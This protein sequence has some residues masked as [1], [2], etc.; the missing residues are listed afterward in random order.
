MRRPCQIAPAVL[1][2][3]LS[4]PVVFAVLRRL[5][6]AFSATRETR[7]QRHFDRRSG[8]TAPHPSAVALEPPTP[9]QLPLK[10]A[11]GL[12]SSSGPSSC[13]PGGL[14]QWSGARGEL[15]PQ[16]PPATSSGRSTCRRCARQICDGRATCWRRQ[17]PEL[18]RL[19]HARFVTEDALARLGPRPPP[20][21]KSSVGRLQKQRQQGRPRPLPPGA[22]RRGHH[23]D[24]DGGRSGRDKAPRHRH[25]ALAPVY[26]QKPHRP[27]ARWL[28]GT[29]SA[30]RAIQRAGY[31]L[32]DYV[33]RRGSSAVGVYLRGSPGFV[34]RFVIDAH[35]R[36]KTENDPGAGIIGGPLR[37][38]DPQ[39]G[40]PGRDGRTSTSQRIAEESLAR[41]RPPPR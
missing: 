32:G 22:G 16:R 12:S 8:Q 41:L 36:R 28:P 20:C 1:A 17:P 5:D 25:H 29:R 34:E 3:P 30:A 40:E 23:R 19:P 21:S 14:V 4:T 10:V 9:R 39:P 27:H 31:H 18:E 6:R 24:P 35:G 37:R 13:W 15:L 7:G 38:R 11:A 2:I 33:G 26:P